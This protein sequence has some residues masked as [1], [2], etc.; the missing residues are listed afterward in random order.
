MRFLVFQVSGSTRG[1]MIPDT[2]VDLVAIIMNLCEYPNYL[3][4]LSNST[5]ES[6]IMV[7]GEEEY[8]GL[9]REA[10]YS[11]SIGLLCL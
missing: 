10:K 1:S 8:L 9:P 4:P 5:I 7:A 3:S 6:Y 2:K 11:S